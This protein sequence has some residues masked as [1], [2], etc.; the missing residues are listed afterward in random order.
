MLGFHLNSFIIKLI[1]AV[2]ILLVMNQISHQLGMKTSWILLTSQYC[3][4][5]NSTSVDQ[6]KQKVMSMSLKTRP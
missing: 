2:K 6:Q 1:F 4:L 5:T 3:K